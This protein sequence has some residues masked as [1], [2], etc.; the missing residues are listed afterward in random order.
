MDPTVPS[1]SAAGNGG[2][3]GGF[4][5][6]LLKTYDMVDDSATDEIVSWSSN[7]TSFIVWNPPE[8]ARLLLPTYFKHNNFSSFI[9]QLNTYGFR[10]IDPE[11]WEFANE[12]FVKDRKHLLKNIHRKKPI[13]SHSSPQCSLVDPERAGF[14]EEI[15]KL[16]L[17]KTALEANVLRFRQERLAAKHRMEELTL[18]AARMERRQETL[19]N[20]IEKAVRDPTFVEHLVHKI[21]SMDVAACNKKRRVPQIDQTRPLGEK[22]ILDNNSSCSRAEFGNIVHQDFPN[23]LRL[24]LPPAVSDINMVSQSTQSSDED[25]ASPRRTS[26]EL[27]DAYMRPEGLLFAP[28]TLDLSDTGTS[29]TFKM[30]AVQQTLNS[31]KEPDSHISC[32]LNLTLASSSSQVNR[33]PS[34]TMMSLFSQEIA[35]DAESRSNTKDSDSRASKNSGNMIDGEATLSLP[36]EGCNTTKEPAARPVRVNDVFWEHFLTER[37]GSSDDEESNSDYQANPY[38]DDNKSSSHGLTVNAKNMER[39]SL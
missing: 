30:D 6:F 23:K 12:G 14:E 8:F 17:E 7:N 31:N 2:S 33:S 21:E 28:K 25:G 11:R 38:E 20:F 39:L 37:P 29:L 22:C 4:A 19:F 18:R 27:K 9:R 1:S 13:H 26:E 35:K 24:E 10:K 32:L 15:E 16:S 36:K 3:G 5:P 34:L